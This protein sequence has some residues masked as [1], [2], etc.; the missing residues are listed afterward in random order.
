MIN[1]FKKKIENNSIELYLNGFK[2]SQNKFNWSKINNIIA[3]KI[4]LI[5][6]DE[7]YLSIKS[8]NQEIVLTENYL[9]WN[10]FL[11]EVYNQFPEIDKNWESKIIQPAF[12][13]NEIELYSRK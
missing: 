10:D 5:T 2:V 8:N 9:G 3:H 11:K 4:D 1:F 6:T 13:R 12:S 7:I